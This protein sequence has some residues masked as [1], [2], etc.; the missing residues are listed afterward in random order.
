MT[1][2]EKIEK[3][4]LFIFN[5]TNNIKLGNNIH[6]DNNSVNCVLTA[7]DENNILIPCG[8]SYCKINEQIYKIILRL[9]KPY[10]A[11]IT[12]ITLVK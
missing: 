1:R 3:K 10:G 5:D 6:L 12:N 2:I 4:L 8:V 7:A 11:E 9:V